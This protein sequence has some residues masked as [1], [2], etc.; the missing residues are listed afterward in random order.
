M[1]VQQAENRV[2]V[3]AAEL[4]SAACTVRYCAETHMSEFPGDL[5]RLLSR[6]PR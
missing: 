6:L 4:T 3:R 1:P 2:L 5:V